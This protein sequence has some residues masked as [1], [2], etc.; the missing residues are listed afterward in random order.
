MPKIGYVQGMN[1]ITSVFLGA[2]LKDSEVYWLMKY[3]LNKKKFEEI[4]M[5]GF[6]RVQ[7]LNYQLDIYVRNYIPELIEF[8]VKI[9]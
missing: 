8:L 2:K 7:I 6:P 1:T 5:D 9:L 3:I 4:L